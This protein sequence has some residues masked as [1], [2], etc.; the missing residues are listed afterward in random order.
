MEHIEFFKIED[1]LHTKFKNIFQI[2]SKN[3]FINRFIIV[4][5]FKKLF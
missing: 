3:L 1:K 5:L 4:K 2:L